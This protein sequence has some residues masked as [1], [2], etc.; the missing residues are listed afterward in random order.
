MS[1]RGKRRLIVFCYH[2]GIAI[3]CIVLAK[4]G[5]IVG[6]ALMPRIAGAILLGDILTFR[7]IPLSRHL[8]ELLIP[9]AV[10]YSCGTVIDLVGSFRCGCG[11]LSHKERHV[12]SPCPMC[13]KVFLFLTCPSC[14]TSIPI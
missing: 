6:S 13:G 11:F 2:A 7:L 5:E 9:E 10:C 14:E 12:F 1:V 4:S 3:F 8:E